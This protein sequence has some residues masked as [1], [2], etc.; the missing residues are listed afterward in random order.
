V[1][2]TEPGAL[3]IGQLGILGTSNAVELTT[4]E[5]VMQELNLVT[6]GEPTPATLSVIHAIQ[7]IAAQP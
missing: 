4:D 1:V 3:G 6:L 7:R 2:A 5:R